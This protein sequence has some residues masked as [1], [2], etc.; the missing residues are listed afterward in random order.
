[1]PFE[2]FDTLSEVFLAGTSWKSQFLLNLGY[3][4]PAWLHPRGPRL[5]FEEACRME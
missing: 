5:D 2:S 1:V 4:D 3:G